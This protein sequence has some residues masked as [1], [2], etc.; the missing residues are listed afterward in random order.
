MTLISARLPRFAPGKF[1]RI[2]VVGLSLLLASTVYAVSPVP[3]EQGWSGYML[4]GGGYTEV[5]S[6]SVAGND[7]IEGGNDTIKSIDQKPKTTDVTHVLGGTEIRYTLPSRNQIFLGGSLED[8]LTLDFAN[9]LGWRK[10]TDKAGIF[11]LGV[12]FSGI[13]VEVWEDPYLAGTRRDATDRD[14]QGLRFEWGRIM[15]SSFDLLIQAKENDIDDELSGTDPSLGCDR[16]CQRL[17]DRNGDQ[18]QARLTYTF[19]WPGGHF[20][21]PQ[22]RL[23]REDRDGDA[24]AR[25]AWDF[26]LS[27]SYMQP[28][29]ILVANALYGE[30]SYD[31]AN[32]LYGRRQDADTLALE[33]TAIY[34][35]PSESRRW[36]LTGGAFWSESDSD[37]RFHDNKLNQVFMGVIYN[38]GNL[39]TPPQ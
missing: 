36:Q 15:G 19:S 22:L 2:L 37:I 5:N 11:Q 31:K 8:R 35:L 28:G 9:Q 30:S 20:L 24:I 7:M 34:N 21:R 29:W 13:P 25:D 32:P 10:Q 18:Y 4:L 26:Q 23:R 12:L 1:T 27:Y 6:N 16:D 17:L 38:F 33:A 39:P 14:S 3:V